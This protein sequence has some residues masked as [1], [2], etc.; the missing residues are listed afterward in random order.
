MRGYS[1][2]VISVTALIVAV[3]VT[4]W[5]CASEEALRESW[6]KIFVGTF[7]VTFAIG[8]ITPLD[9]RDCIGAPSRIC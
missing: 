2:E 9:D 3:I 4:G 5:S 6:L 8:V 1:I 7:L